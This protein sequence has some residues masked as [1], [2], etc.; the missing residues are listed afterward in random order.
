MTD[1]SL[2]QVF[3]FNNAGRLLL[4]LGETG[5]AGTDSNHFNMPTGVAIAD[6]GT[7]YVSDGYGNRGIMRFTANGK[8]LLEWGKKGYKAGEFNI[9]HGIAPDRNGLIYMADRENSRIQVFSATGRFIKQLSGNRG[10]VNSVDFDPQR[11]QLLASDDIAFLNFKHQGSDLLILDTTQAR[12]K[13]GLAGVGFI[14]V[15][16]PGIM[17]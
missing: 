12:Y 9:P 10:A 5:V 11:S 15:V 6:D 17:I 3:K 14:M 1:V 13:Q 8:Y 16:P 4:Q 2:H 7:F